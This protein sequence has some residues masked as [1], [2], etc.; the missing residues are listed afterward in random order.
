M[1]EVLYKAGYLIRITSW[2]NDGDNYNK[3]EVSGLTKEQAK[4]T[5]A[6]SKLFKSKNSVT[7]DA[8][9]NISD[10][11]EAELEK[12]KQAFLNHNNQYPDLDAEEELKQFPEGER[13]EIFM[14]WCLERAGDLGL[15]GGEYFYTRVC[16]KVEVYYFASDV[17]VE[18]KTQ[19]FNH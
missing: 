6:F 15:A 17:L 4:E 8:I 3:K 18:N 14:G 12:V 2:E 13:D 10:P 1:T 11:N 16:E 5:V 7:M 19:E 9:G